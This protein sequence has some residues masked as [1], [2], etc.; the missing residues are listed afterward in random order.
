MEERKKIFYF[1]E[2]T[3]RILNFGCSLS[4]FGYLPDQIIWN[5]NR[6]LHA[7]FFCIVL[8][9]EGQGKGLINGQ[10]AKTKFAP[11]SLHIYPPGTVLHTIQASLHDE[12]FFTYTGENARK[13]MEMGFE[14]CHFEITP[15]ISDV[16]SRIRKELLLPDSPLKADKMDLLALEILAAIQTSRGSLSEKYR[17]DGTRFPELTSYLEL[18]FLE[19]PALPFLLHKFGLSR[20]TFF[21]LW[22]KKYTCSYTKFLNELK[23]AHGEKLLI[24]TNLSIGEIAKQC[25]FSS[26]TYFIRRFKKHYGLPPVLYKKQLKEKTS[27]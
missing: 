19:N 5:T 6:T 20:R 21:R 18:H 1:P 2:K 12:I 22:K 4:A 11:P 15:E 25:A 27:L 17:E 8:C 9:R 24:S 14:N 10:V 13:M 16:I 26:P 23:I 7:L 3:K